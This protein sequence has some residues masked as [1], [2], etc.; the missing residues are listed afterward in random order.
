M[1]LTRILQ[2]L[3]AIGFGLSLFVHVAALLG[4][5][6]FGEAAFFLHGGI[7]VL[8]IPT[9]AITRGC[10]KRDTFD[11][12]PAWMQTAFPI[13]FAYAMF[14]F[15]RGAGHHGHDL[16]LALRMF[17]GHWMI[18]YFAVFATL[19]AHIHRETPHDPSSPVARRYFPH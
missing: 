16:T 8:A 5:T 6:P 19:T 11:G 18:F 15:L 4:A 1:R 2:Y 10:D 17:S 14:N 3:A 12:C 13:L 7:F 9:M